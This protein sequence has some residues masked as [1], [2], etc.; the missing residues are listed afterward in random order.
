M[1][2][3]SVT[4]VLPYRDVPHAG[5]FYVWQLHKVLTEDLELDVKYLVPLLPSN[6]HALQQ[7]PR[8]AGEPRLALKR[9]LWRRVLARLYS[10]WRRWDPDAPLLASAFDL[11]TKSD[12]RKELGVADIVDFQWSAWARLVNCVPRRSA[13]RV[14]A[15]LHDVSSQRAARELQRAAGPARR[16]KWRLALIAAK[17]FESRILRRSDRVIVF[18]EKDRACLDPRGRHDNVR[19]V[20]PPLAIDGARS[21]EP[22]R[23]PTVVLVGY[24]FRL[25]NREALEWMTQRI[26][27]AVRS[28]Q[29]SAELRVVGTGLSDDEVAR[30]RRIPGVKPVGFVQDLEDAYNE[31]SVAAVPLLSGAG[32][33]F[34]TIEPMI[35][36]VPVVSTPL[37]AEGIGSAELY[38]AVTSDPEQFAA[39]LIRAL[40]KDPGERDRAASTRD[41]A[42]DEFGRDAFRRSIE[43]IYLGAS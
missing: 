11:Y 5:G 8:A 27:P 36:G 12:I 25:E 32:V 16:L 34:K 17:R 37:G 42:L 6:E 33:K 10:V 39:A 43:E 1:R 30:L 28:A 35:R 29:P 13:A 26:W 20:R 24:F 41:W 3:T 31:V 4:P 2:L 9:T 15:T 22:G 21:V 14:V 38:T 18:S 23:T 7:Q 40:T 19:V